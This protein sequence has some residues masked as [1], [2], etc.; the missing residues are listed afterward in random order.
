[1]ASEQIANFPIK[2]LPIITDVPTTRFER[3]P[4]WCFFAENCL[5][6][7]SVSIGWVSKNK[8]SANKIKIFHDTERHVFQ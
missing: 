1:M 4:T 8:F 6:L 7:Y 3:G 5:G 2:Y